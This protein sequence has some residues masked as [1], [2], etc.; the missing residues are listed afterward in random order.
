MRHTSTNVDA[1]AR[2]ALHEGETLVSDWCLEKSVKHIQEV[3]GKEITF[4]DCVLV[5]FTEINNKIK[6]K[7]DSMN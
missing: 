3:G 6:I 2:T 7:Y 5:K 1:K 4:G